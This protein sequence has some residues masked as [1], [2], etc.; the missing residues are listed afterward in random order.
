MTA[1][2]RP[3]IGRLTLAGSLLI[4]LA[5]IIWIALTTPDQLPAHIGTD[6]EP[7]RWESKTWVLGAAT[8]TGTA[9]LV[10]LRGCQAAIRRVHV[11]LISLPTARGKKYWTDPERRPELNRRLNADLELIFGLT[12]LLLAVAF[13]GLARVAAGADGHLTNIAILTYAV[14]VT[15]TM[16]I[17]FT[18]P[19]YRAPADDTAN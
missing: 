4:Y 13:T 1:S 8:I 17:L 9:L 16:I 2:P 5:A 6:G 7:T 15:T 10:I 11:D 12:Y 14:A 18:G 19:R 3:T